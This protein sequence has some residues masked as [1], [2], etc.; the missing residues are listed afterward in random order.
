MTDL[1]ALVGVRQTFVTG[2][3]ADPGAKLPPLIV[4]APLVPGSERDA[5][6]DRAEIG[7]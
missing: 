6:R 5:D 4:V 2:D 7:C 1:P 3:A